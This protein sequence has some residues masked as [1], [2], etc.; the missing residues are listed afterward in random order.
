MMKIAIWSIVIIIVEHNNTN[1][2]LY[3]SS[4]LLILNTIFHHIL[5]SA[6][7]T[8]KLRDLKTLYMM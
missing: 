6:G 2:I 5:P 3:S 8:A 1:I 4:L 7:Q